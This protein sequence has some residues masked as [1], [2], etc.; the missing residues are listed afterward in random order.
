M[1]TTILIETLYDLLRKN[2]PETAKALGLID[3]A[4]AAGVCTHERRQS[5]QIVEGL[6]KALEGWWAAEE[7]IG[8]AIERSRQFD[9]HGYDPHQFVQACVPLFSLARPMR[10]VGKKHSESEL[11]PRIMEA[12]EM[13]AK[14]NFYIADGIE[15][16]RSKPPNMLELAQVLESIVVPG[17]V[18]KEGEEADRHFDKAWRRLEEELAEVVQDQGTV[19]QPKGVNEESAPTVHEDDLE[20]RV[21]R[22]TQWT[23]DWMREVGRVGLEL[24]ENRQKGE[25]LKTR[26]DALEVAIAASQTAHF[27]DPRTGLSDHSSFSVR[28]NRLLDRAHH[29]GE[30]FSI[31]VIRL[32]NF[33]TLAASIEADVMDLMIR[34]IAENIRKYLEEDDFIARIAPDRLGIL[35]PKTGSER[36]VSVIA[37]LNQSLTL[38]S[39]SMN[40]GIARLHIIGGSLSFGQGM[41]VKDIMVSVAQLANE[42]AS[43]KVGAKLKFG[44]S[45]VETDVPKEP[46]FD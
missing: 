31:G 21:S 6:L 18:A 42:L 13:L 39:S 19:I 46:L 22:V 11:A 7:G 23:E 14:N 1:S 25:K 30:I 27:I 40:P 36:C 33:E 41:T 35:F 3:K 8:L 45:I 38:L 20:S 43:A 15:T 10:G 29:L 37:E 24:D 4:L 17:K 9:G 44:N 12:L 16:I 34:E 26:I 2:P 5:R 32:G 28:L